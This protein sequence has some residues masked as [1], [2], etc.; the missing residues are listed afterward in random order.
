[1]KRFFSKI[2]RFFWSWGFLKFVLGVIALIILLYVE[3]DWRGAHAWAVTK[4]KWEAKGEKFDYSKFIPPPVPDEQNL[5]AISLFELKMEKSTYDP[6]V[7]HLGM[8][9]LERAM[10]SDDSAIELPHGGN[11]ERG[12]APDMGKIRTTLAKD[13]GIVFKGQTPP[14]DMLAQFDAIFPFTADLRATAATR[15]YFRL[16]M[17]YAVSPPVLRPFGPVTEPIRLAQLLTAHAILSLE[18]QEPD[19]AL[20]DIKVNYIALSGLKRDPTLVG[21]L[22]AIGTAA[23][24]NAAIYEGLARHEWNDAQLLDMQKMLKPINFLADFQFAMRCEVAQSI[25]DINFFQH[26]S[27]S[28]LR[29]LFGWLDSDESLSVLVDVPWPSGWWDQNKS[30]EANFVFQSLATVDSHAQRAFPKK[31]DGLENEIAQAEARW[32]ASAPWKILANVSAGPIVKAM[33]K[34]SE[35]QVWL[36]ETR[37]A[38]ALERYRLAH[39]VYPGTLEALVPACIDE[40]PHDI[41]NGE[42]YHYRFNADGTFL[43]YSVGWNQVDDGGKVVF[44]KDAPTQVDYEQG[45]WVWPVVDG[46]RK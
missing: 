9:A 13:Y 24:S 18:N 26:T 39:G 43:L 15:P 45:D 42:P 27:R 30:R 4:A 36:D 23:I 21:G 7:P 6:S 17:N 16:N 35:A 2:G 37:I 3:E 41:M 38:C 34:Y 8:P 46:V 32:D 40:L 44:K 31:D 22:V 14:R 19:L 5:A 12:E 10:R 1:M 28:E 29:R 25:E 33:Q 20:E 11:W